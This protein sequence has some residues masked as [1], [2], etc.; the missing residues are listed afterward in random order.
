MNRIATAQARLEHATDLPAVLDA[1]Y[2]AFADIL[3]VL[4]HPQEQ[5]EDGFPAFVLSASAAASGRDCI[6]FAP[7]LPPAPA[8]SGRASIGDLLEGEHW[9]QVA[10]AIAHVSQSLV[11]SLT[12]VA[13]AALSPDDQAACHSAVTYAGQINELLAGAELL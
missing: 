13:V 8:R 6:A 4:R 5:A 2:D 12:A 1:S 3:A 7:S 9:I 10:I 11:Y